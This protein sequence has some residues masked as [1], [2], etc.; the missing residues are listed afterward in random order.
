M[1]SP[2]ADGSFP[3]FAFSSHAVLNEFSVISSRC[4]QL[5]AAKWKFTW[6]LRWFSLNVEKYIMRTKTWK[7]VGKLLY[8]V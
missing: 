8:F 1:K 6:A 7:I 5:R 4:A 2:F 3:N